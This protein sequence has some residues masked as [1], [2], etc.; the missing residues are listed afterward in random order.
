M[1]Q[2]ARAA[3]QKS[4]AEREAIAAEKARIDAETR[5]R[6]YPRNHGR[7]KIHG[8]NTSLPLSPSGDRPIDELSRW[9]ANTNWADARRKISAPM[10]IANQFSASSLHVE[11]E[12]Q[13]A[14]GR[15]QGLDIDIQISDDI[16]S[17][18]SDPQKLQMELSRLR[19]QSWNVSS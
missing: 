17:R 15:A 6:R 9:R 12:E 13:R 7:L 19:V 10:M 3:K 5:A 11:P 8:G 2:A 4:L 16:V 1:K 18:E 14:Q